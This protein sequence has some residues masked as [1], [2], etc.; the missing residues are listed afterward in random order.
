MRSVVGTPS[1]QA[2]DTFICGHMDALRVAGR[3]MFKH[4]DQFE[5]SRY[6]QSI[7]WNEVESPHAARSLGGHP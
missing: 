7:G 3:I 4:R 2:L 6:L 1:A 5:W